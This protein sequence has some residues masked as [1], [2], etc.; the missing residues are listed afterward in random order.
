MIRALPGVAPSVRNFAGVADRA[1]SGSG[2]PV[3][4]CEGPELG[5]WCS[6]MS[7]SDPGT[8]ATP[9]EKGYDHRTR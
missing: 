6:W 5:I 8:F 7:Q 4:S 9:L 3:L 2:V 1:Q